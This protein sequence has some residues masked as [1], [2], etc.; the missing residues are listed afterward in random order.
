[1]S[2]VKEENDRVRINKPKWLRVKL[3]TGENYK[4]VRSL[5]DEHK[6][7]TICESQLFLAD[8]GSIGDNACYSLVLFLGLSRMDRTIKIPAPTQI[9]ESATLKAGQ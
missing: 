4:K 1:M 9:A 6:L 3:P 5:V 7:H 8:T 2:E